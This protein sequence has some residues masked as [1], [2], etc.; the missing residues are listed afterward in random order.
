ME[1]L[2]E[3]L[4]NNNKNV[5]YFYNDAC[6]HCKQLKPQITLLENKHPNNFFQFNTHEDIEVSNTFSIEYVPTLVVVE[7]KKYRKLEGFKKIEE[8]YENVIKQNPNTI[9][10]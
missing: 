4:K 5:I 3:S 10:G 1:K 6:G 7:N 8:F 2:I 9:R